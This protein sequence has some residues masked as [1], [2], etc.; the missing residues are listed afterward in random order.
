M[1][2]VN[3]S[4]SVRVLNF[5]VSSICLIVFKGRSAFDQASR[6]G[7]QQILELLHTDTQMLL[8]RKES[9]ARRTYLLKKLF[10]LFQKGR[11]HVN[12][13]HLVG[14]E[15]L[16]A[17]AWV[18]GCGENE[19][20]CQ[21]PLPYALFLKICDYIPL[22]QLW[23]GEV[24]RLE[25]RCCSDAFNDVVRGSLVIIN[26]IFRDVQSQLKLGRDHLVGRFN[27]W[28]VHIAS[29]PAVQEALR[30]GRF[31]IPMS[32]LLGIIEEHDLESVLLRH[33][34]GISCDAK[35]A[36]KIL[37]LC[38]EVLM[39]YQWQDSPALYLEPKKC[40]KSETDDVNQMKTDLE[41]EDSEDSDM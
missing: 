13:S 28:L 22:P 26:E 41:S 34:G 32:T 3:P 33:A 19:R 25:T 17:L 7:Q 30:Q 11:A 36:R 1:L 24:T 27:G 16:G 21:H 40:E 6:R 20:L 23:A 5:T 15:S 12:S 18:F 39:W 37:N 29:N 2:S 10:V 31:P 38:K 9:H 8:M 35:V 14:S 4:I